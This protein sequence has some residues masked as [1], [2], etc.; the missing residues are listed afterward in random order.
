MKKREYLDNEIIQTP[1]LILEG[2]PDRAGALKSARRLITSGRGHCFEDIN[3]P[4]AFSGRGCCKTKTTKR[5][6][7]FAR[8]IKQNNKIKIKIILF[9]FYT[10]FYLILISRPLGRLKKTCRVLQRPQSRLQTYLRNLKY[11]YA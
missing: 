2:V 9:D 5:R 7:R 3:A 10:I 8:E 6:S 11:I 4:A 1:P